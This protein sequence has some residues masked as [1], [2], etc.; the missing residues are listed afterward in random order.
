MDEPVVAFSFERTTNTVLERLSEYQSSQISHSRFSFAFDF[1]PRDISASQGLW[2][3]RAKFDCARPTIERAL[4]RGG[5][6][7]GRR[8]NWSVTQFSGLVVWAFPSPPRA[9]V[10]HD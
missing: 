3:G 4:R 7:H 6:V 5:L 9:R 1:G 8:L 10:P 2:T